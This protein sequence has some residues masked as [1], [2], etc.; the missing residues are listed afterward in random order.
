LITCLSLLKGNSSFSH[1]HARPAPIS[2]CLYIH[3]PR[4]LSVCVAGW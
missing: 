2:V 4:A 1:L 3:I